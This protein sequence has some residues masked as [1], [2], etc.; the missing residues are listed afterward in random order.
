MAMMIKW[1]ESRVQDIIHYFTTVVPKS[2]SGVLSSRLLSTTHIY[3]KTPSP[4]NN[5]YSIHLYNNIYIYIY[6]TS[7]DKKTMKEA[8]VL[9]LWCW[10]PTR[11]GGGDRP[12]A[13]SHE[14]S[15]A[16]PGSKHRSLELLLGVYH[17]ANPFSKAQASTANCCGKVLRASLWNTALCN[18][19]LVIRQEKGKRPCKKISVLELFSA[20][21][22]I[23]GPN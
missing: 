4:L 6:N 14:K 19:R 2:L 21:L 10:W 3:S 17:K 9:S 23:S 15:M 7:E 13:R 20:S 22:R 16:T 12:C 1:E 18:R 11:A 5:I 8:A